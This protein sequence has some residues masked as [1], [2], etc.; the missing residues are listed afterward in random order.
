MEE[1]QHEVKSQDAKPVA[2]RL[3]QGVECDEVAD[4]AAEYLEVWPHVLS[5][6]IW[7]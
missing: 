6:L 4:P 5:F 7:F 3:D 2:I 1:V